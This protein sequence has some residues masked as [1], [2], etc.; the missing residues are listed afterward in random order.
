MD[1]VVAAP[2]NLDWLEECGYTH[3]S[4]GL[5]YDFERFKRRIREHIEEYN[6]LVDVINDLV[7]EK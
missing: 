7:G 2:D 4:C 1:K 6:Q 5:D 3:T